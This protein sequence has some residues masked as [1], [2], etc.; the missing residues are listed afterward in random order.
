M[1]QDQQVDCMVVEVAP[2]MMIL[3]RLVV[4]VVKV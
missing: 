1:E 4:L 2:V 3:M